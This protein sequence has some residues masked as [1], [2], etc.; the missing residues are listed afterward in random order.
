MRTPSVLLSSHPGEKVPS[1][2]NTAASKNKQVAYC[3]RIVKDMLRLKDAFGFSKPIDQLW[4]VDQLPGYFDIVTNPMDLDT[5]RR[6]LEA[7]FYLSP[8]G[9]QEVE[10]LMFD[11]NSFTT[12]MRQIFNNARTYNR[13]GDIFYEAATRLL[14]KFQT[15]M[16]QM[17]SQQQL[18]EQAAKKNTKKRKKTFSAPHPDS[19]KPADSSKKKKAGAAAVAAAWNSNGQPKSA[20]KKKKSQSS[21][22]KTS[23]TVARKPKPAKPAAVE[24]R[25]TNNNMTVQDME[26][27]LRALKKQRMLNDAESPPAATPAAGAPSYKA[28]ARALYKVKMTYEEKL[29]LS[30]NVSRLP[31]DKLTKIIAM[32]KSATGPMEVN[33]NEEIELDIDSM[34]NETLREMEAYVNQALYGKK[35]A[36]PDDGPNSDIYNMSKTDV[37]SEI[38]KL[39]AVLR[40]RTKGKSKELQDAQPNKTTNK[41]ERS[42]YDSD[43]SSESGDSDASSSGDDS[44]SDESDS[45]GDESGRDDMRRR[46]EQNLAHQQAMQAAGTPLPSPP[47]KGSPAAA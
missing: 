16:K 27:R 4:S 24:K 1:L 5:V 8:L 15:K 47:Y 39:S 37:V 12:D 20:A 2:Q 21:K 9:K 33:N 46:R 36:R 41:K 35:K 30:Q 31:P 44:S 19:R 28:Q 10:E 23:A 6:R 25:P 42:F 13:A 22:P 18:V 32:A 7:A 3:L 14:D 40:K 45:S 34:N 43:S 11:E 29:E 26:V 38:E 17:P